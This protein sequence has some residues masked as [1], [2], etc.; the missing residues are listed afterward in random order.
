[1]VPAGAMHA[2]TSSSLYRTCEPDL[3]GFKN[4]EGLGVRCMTRCMT[5]RNFALFLGYASGFFPV[6][7]Y[8]VEVQVTIGIASRFVDLICIL[9]VLLN[10]RNLAQ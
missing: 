10:S 4:L 5:K 7:V 2:I 1:M 8:L 6:A 3:L 9:H